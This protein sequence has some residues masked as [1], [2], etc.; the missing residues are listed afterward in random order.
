MAKLHFSRTSATYIT[1]HGTSKSF[2]ENL[3]IKLKDNF[4]SLNIDEGTSSSMDKII[5]VFVRFYED[6]QKM[7]VTD[8]LASRKENLS[9]SQNIFKQIS[10]IFLENELHF[11]QIVSCLFDNCNAMRGCKAGVETQIRNANPNLLNIHGDTVHIIHNSAKKF[12]SFFENYLES[13]GSDLYFDIQDSPKAKEL[14]SEIQT[15]LNYE[16]VLHVLRLVDNRFIQILSVCEKLYKLNDAL[17]VF[18]CSF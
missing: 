7:V 12:F 11:N 15:L 2:R 16:N 5:N 13:I 1:A 9:T 8:H 18:Y 14:F 3:I 17:R 6:E 4:F 10:S